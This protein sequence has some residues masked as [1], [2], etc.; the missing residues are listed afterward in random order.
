[1]N[2]EGKTPI[3]VLDSMW[4]S[5]TKSKEEIEY[6]NE[7]R[8]IKINKCPLCGGEAEVD[9]HSECYGHECWTTYNVVCKDCNITLNNTYYNELE[10]I[11]AWNKLED[12]KK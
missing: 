3:E 8:A 7:L 4:G 1:M 12:K 5:I 11:K 10:A 2:G 9:S 6:E